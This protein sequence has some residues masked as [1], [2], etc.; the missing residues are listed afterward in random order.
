MCVCVY[1][2]V[3]VCVCARLQ[4]V[5]VCVY[6]YMHVCLWVLDKCQLIIYHSVMLTMT[7]MHVPEINI[8][9]HVPRSSG[10][11]RTDYSVIYIAC[12]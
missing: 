2:C 6:M 3:C 1:V 10:N 4:Q 11:V 12:T 7:S 8:D 9:E 5:C